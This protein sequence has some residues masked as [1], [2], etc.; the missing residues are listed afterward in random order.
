MVDLKALDPKTLRA[1][2]PAAMA[3]LATRML[4]ELSAQSRQIQQHEELAQRYEREI[5][6]KDAKLEK[7]TFELARRACP[8][9]CV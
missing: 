8:E 4:L 9:F 3:E 6:F 2:E 1:M 7:I 5:K